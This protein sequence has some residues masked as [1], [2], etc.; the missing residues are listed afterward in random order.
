[1]ISSPFVAALNHVLAQS[2]WARAK[3][4]PFA[5]RLARLQLPIGPIDFA[6]TGEGYAQAAGDGADAAETPVD[7]TITLPLETPFLAL[8]GKEKVFAAARIE[9]SADFAEALGF[10][11]R[12]LSWDAEADLARVVGDIAA[13]RL[14]G[15]LNAFVG[16]QKQ[17]AQRLAENVA[18]YASEEQK[19]LLGGRDM[20]GFKDR[21]AALGVGISALEQR[22]QKLSARP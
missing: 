6:I 5:G 22:L 14:M 1:M 9:G 17:A 15:G 8:Q 20:A 18:E 16:W 4:L 13:H 19:L 10:V 21:V 11:L 3:L 2:S 7:V 12:N